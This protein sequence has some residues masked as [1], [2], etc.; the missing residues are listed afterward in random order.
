MA[1]GPCGGA[2]GAPWAARPAAADPPK[3]GDAGWLAPIDGYP[4]LM[5]Y[6]ADV[7]DFCTASV[8]Y[9]G[10]QYGLTYYSDYMAFF[11]DESKL[12]QAG[13]GA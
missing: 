7:D 9:K 3:R 1:P 2:A 6:N 4:E 8:K 12:K 13:I 10:K 5:K 11:Y